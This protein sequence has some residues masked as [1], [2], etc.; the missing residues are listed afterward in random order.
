VPARAVTHGTRKRARLR[1]LG[2]FG[3]KHLLRANLSTRY[4]KSVAAASL[5]ALAFG[6]AT[7][8]AAP[9]SRTSAHPT[10]EVKQGSPLAVDNV[11]SRPTAVGE[12]V[13]VFGSGYD[14]LGGSGLVRALQRRLVRAGDE[15]GPID[16]RYGP[17]TEQAVGRF[18]AEHGLE[19]DGTAGPHT[20]ATLSAR[21]IVLYPGA[22]SE[23]P[24]GSQLVRALQR[25]LSQAG[26]NPGPIDGRFGPLTEQAVRG[27]Q[28]AHGLHVDGI[29]AGQTFVDLRNQ[30]RSRSLSSRTPAGYQR[31]TRVSGAAM[32]RP[33]QPTGWPTAGW[34]VLFVL[35]GLVTL[36]TGALYARRR[37]DHRLTA[38]PETGNTRTQSGGFEREAV[39]VAPPGASEELAGARPAS[40]YPDAGRD[41]SGEF[42]LGALLEGRG[43]FAGAEAAYRR[44]DERGDAAA[45]CKLGVLLEGQGEL[46]GA[47]AA[48]RRADERGNIAAACKLGVLLEGQRELIEAEAAYRRADER[49]HAAAACKLGVLL[50][51]Q[52]ELI[53][54]GAAYGQADE[55]G[56]ANGA[57]NLGLLLAQQG[58][59]AGAVAALRRADERGHAAAAAQL[60]AWLEHQGDHDAASAAHQRGDERGEATGAAELGDALV[61]QGDLDGAVAALE[62]ADELGHPAAALKLGVLLERRG[63]LEG[64]CAAY[65]R[66]D[67]LGD[68]N[69]AFNLGCLLAEHDDFDGAIAAFGRADSRGDAAGASNLGV[70][71]Q[72]QGDLDGAAAAYRRA[73]RRGDASGAFNLGAVLQER[74]DLAGAEAAYRR[75]EQSGHAEVANLA[76]AA[77]LDLNLAV[78]GSNR[79]NGGDSRCSV[80]T[81]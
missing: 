54:A 49:G 58:D 10:A 21:T 34:L 42:N 38:V 27:F 77:L 14:G 72:R 73:D 60:G 57:F 26:S 71:L 64:A 8:L 41:A 31:P 46:A 33:S 62:R 7:V 17:L 28:A 9:G 40:R 12:K 39:P 66:A 68:A 2:I 50:E 32:V 69:G 16:G 65:A 4:I 15:P 23:E 11:V 53:E 70:L 19:V 61:K 13:L 6:P 35:L 37:S 44:A 56:D 81:A 75:A 29:A 5:L 47:E 76:R 18:Q 1:H 30:A 24:Q 59:H 78:S 22:G 20:L 55:R 80:A 63:D 52:G 25:D 43:H 45:A 79:G 3:R 36:L 48:Y 67:R 74:G 51:G